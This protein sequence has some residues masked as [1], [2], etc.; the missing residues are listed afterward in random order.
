VDKERPGQYTRE[1]QKNEEQKTF[2]EIRNARHAGSA[3]I[4][5]TDPD[6]LCYRNGAFGPHVGLSR[7]PITPL[8]RHLPN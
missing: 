5:V 4:L 6:A 3:E 8:V 1:A 2:G 7:I